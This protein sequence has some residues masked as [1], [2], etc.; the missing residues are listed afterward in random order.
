MLKWLE[1]GLDGL[2]RWLVR[3]HSAALVQLAL[4]WI[5]GYFSRPL[6]HASAIIDLIHDWYGHM[7]FLTCIYSP[8][9]TINPT[10]YGIVHEEIAHIP[11][12]QMH[13]SAVESSLKGHLRTFYGYLTCPSGLCRLN[14][15]LRSSYIWACGSLGKVPGP[16][17]PSYPIAVASVVSAALT[18]SVDPV[19]QVAD[20]DL[21]LVDPGTT[22]PLERAAA[23]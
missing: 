1:G 2:N 14:I 20:P 12:V 11:V 7:S 16:R 21:E 17:H 8:N 3:F 19:A 18:N 22:N 10:I 13:E 9:P 15:T 23:S 6:S 4:V 5:A